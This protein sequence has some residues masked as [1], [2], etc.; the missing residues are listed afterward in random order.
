[1]TQ[2]KLYDFLNDKAGLWLSLADYVE[3]KLAILEHEETS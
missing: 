2:S 1:M 3:G